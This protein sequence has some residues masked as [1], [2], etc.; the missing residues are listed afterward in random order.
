MDA[1][2]TKQ[3]LSRLLSY[4]WIK[5][6]G[7]AVAII[8]LWSLIF[9]MTATRITPAQQ[10]TVFNHYG[11]VALDYTSFYNS[12]DTAISRDVFSYEVLE[13][14][15]IDLATAGDDYYMLC[16][17]RFST[18]QG[19]LMFIPNI[20]DADT[21]QTSTVDGEE[22]TTYTHSYLESFYARYIGYV[23]SWDKFIDGAKAYVSSFYG[24][25]YANGKLNEAKAER[26][27]LARIDKNNDKRFKRKAQIEEGVKA[28]F[29]RLEKYRDALVQF[30]AYLADGTVRLENVVLLDADGKPMLDNKGN[31]LQQ[32]NYAL[33]ISP[34][35]KNT[36]LTDTVYYS[37]ELEDGTRQACADNM[38][39]M[40][41]SLPDMDDDYL[42][43]TL[44]YLN[45]VIESSLPTQSA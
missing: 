11:N 15:V 1:K 41:F 8:I 13:T 22:I 23:M 29:E 39:A 24:E 36:K 7:I 21:A 14:D 27:F 4:D 20:D 5:I 10:F 12:Y 9:T 37:L 42:Y 40:V 25:D 17:T 28:E 43:E 16:D 31:I 30:E 19:D 45:T 35:G 32:G 34:D 38:C 6:I 18:G 3:R 33:N 26:E 44:L 2:I